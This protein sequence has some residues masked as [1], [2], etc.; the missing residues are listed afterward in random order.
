MTRPYSL[1]ILPSKMAQ[2][3]HAVHRQCPHGDTGIFDVPSTEVA[4]GHEVSRFAFLSASLHLRSSINADVHEVALAGELR[5]HPRIEV[6]GDRT[7]LFGPRL[8]SHCRRPD[9][10]GDLIHRYYP[11]AA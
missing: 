4:C 6:V 8:V 5:E 7:H 2:S 3:R 11:A 9:L 10:L 1:P